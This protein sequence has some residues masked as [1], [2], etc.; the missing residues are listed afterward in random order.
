MKTINPHN[1]KAH[2]NRRGLTLDQLAEIS[3]VN[4]ATINKIERGV[5]TKSR[6]VT[7][8]RLAGALEV[9]E[10]ELTGPEIDD[11]FEAR[12]FGPKSQ[13]NLRMP[14][15]VRNAL[16]LVA[17]RY[18]V[19]PNAILQLAPFLF[20][21]AAE[22]SLAERRLKL[23]QANM[24][25]RELL[26]LDVPTHIGDVISHYWR[27]DEA[28]DAE[29][30][31][32]ARNDICALT[33]PEEHFPADYDCDSENPLTQHF[34]AMGKQ[35]GLANFE[36]WTPLY[37]RPEYE[38]L[39]GDIERMTGGDWQ[40]TSAIM[41]GDAA[42]HTMPAAVRIEGQAAIAAWARAE[43]GRGQR[44]RF[45]DFDFGNSFNEGDEEGESHV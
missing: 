29:Q 39:E 22:A 19:K 23:E 44:E 16:H 43:G 7:I 18:H 2:R 45:G 27:G 34:I 26:D 12:L 42:L 9:K 11:P 17:D 24:K 30:N 31:S 8:V 13:Y 6:S 5:L 15:H 25:L 3:K 33:I 4:R 14:N 41:S 21:C 28:L 37:I 40:A 35:S 10:E 1:L 36:S 38:L 20:L 32:I